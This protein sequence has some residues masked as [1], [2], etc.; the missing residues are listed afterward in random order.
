MQ[1]LLIVLAVI[2]FPGF[3]CAPVEN[4]QKEPIN[5]G[6]IITAIYQ[7]MM[8]LFVLRRSLDGLTNQLINVNQA[9]ITVPVTIFPNGIF[10]NGINGR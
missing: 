2:G 7:L 8:Q 5:E 1:I 9:I 4:E 10:P 6:L 3:L